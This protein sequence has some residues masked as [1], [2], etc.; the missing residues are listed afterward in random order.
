MAVR[1]EDRDNDQIRPDAN[2]LLRRVWLL[3]LSE[4][5]AVAD[6]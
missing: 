3:L 2:Y 6:E 5:G 1:D 4:G